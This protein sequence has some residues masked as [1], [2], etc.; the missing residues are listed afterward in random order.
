MSKVASTL[1]IQYL[2]TVKYNKLC[3]LFSVQFKWQLQPKI[4]NNQPGIQ[5]VTYEGHIYTY[6]IEPYSD[7]TGVAVIIK[8]DHRFVGVMHFCDVPA[9]GYIWL[10]CPSEGF[11][12]L[13]D[14]IFTVFTR[15]LTSALNKL[16]EVKVQQQQYHG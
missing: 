9:H 14:N 4:S 13:P 8:I 12:D 15:H 11:M 1:Y 7:K 16:P 6:I 5:N 2:D 3:L 10:F